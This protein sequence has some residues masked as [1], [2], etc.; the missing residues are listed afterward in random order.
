MADEE[1]ALS[2][3]NLKTLFNQGGS[4]MKLT[5]S[6]LAISDDPDFDHVVPKGTSSPL[7]ARTSRGAPR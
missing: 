5:G 3:K 7:P 4:Q 6:R 1:Q 2:Q